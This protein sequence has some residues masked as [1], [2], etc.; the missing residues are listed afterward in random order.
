MYAVKSS[1][2]TELLNCMM[3]TSAHIKND[4]LS[5]NEVC[6]FIYMKEHNVYR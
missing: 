6:Y 5:V 3:D 2:R 4:E 1:T